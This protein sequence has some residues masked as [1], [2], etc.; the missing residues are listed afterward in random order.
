M[1]EIQLKANFGEERLSKLTTFAL[2]INGSVPS[3][4][5]NQN[6]AIVDARL[7]AQSRDADALSHANFLRPALDIIM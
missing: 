5:K 6:S 4:P 2:T 1:T 7:I 3:D